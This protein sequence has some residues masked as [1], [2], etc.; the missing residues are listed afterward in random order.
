MRPRSAFWTAREADA[1][2]RSKV[3]PGKTTWTP[4]PP[5]FRR[6]APR[7]AR[8]ALAPRRPRDAPT[9]WPPQRMDERPSGVHPGRPGWPWPPGDPRSHP[10]EL[11]RHVSLRTSHGVHPGRPGWLRPPGNPGMHQLRRRAMVTDSRPIGVH[12]GWPGWHWPPGDPGSRQG[13]DGLDT[14]Y[15]HRVHPGWPG[16][17]KPPGDPGLRQLG[18]GGWTPPPFRSG[19]RTTSVVPAAGTRAVPPSERTG[20][21]RSQPLGW[22]APWDRSRTSNRGGERG[23][24]PPL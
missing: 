6:S 1:P 2:R 8:V 24:P 23:A 17:L 22:H 4:K 7:M 21:P 11:H 18:Q 14:H 16:R 12:P 3:A 19:P 13:Q 15:L 20:G 5:D 10:G 9:L